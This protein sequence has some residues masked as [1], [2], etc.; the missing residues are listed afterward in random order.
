[1]I[2]LNIKVGSAT[3]QIESETQ[4][5]AVAEAG[6]WGECP[7]KCGNCGSQNVGF[8]SRRPSGHL[9]VGMKCADCD[10]SFNF[11]QNKEA[12][13]LFIKHD[14]AWQPPYSG[15]G[16]QQGNEPSQ[17]NYAQPDNDSIPF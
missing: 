12:G 3:I 6:F 5:G 16:N 11:G 8:F 17:S 7:T 13:G 1:M 14:E 15:G 2:K 10:H 4:V 9:Y